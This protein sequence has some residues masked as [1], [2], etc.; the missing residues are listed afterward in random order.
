M[1][2]FAYFFDIGKH[3]KEVPLFQYIFL[4]WGN[5]SSRSSLLNISLIR[6][7]ILRSYP[8][9]NIFSETQLWCPLFLLF[10][11]LEKPF[12][13]SS[14]LLNRSLKEIPIFWTISIYGNISGSNPLLN[15][16]LEKHTQKSLSFEHFFG[17]GKYFIEIPHFWM[18][19]WFQKTFKRSSPH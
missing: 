15:I 6:E 14:P 8:L 16:F 7:I 1:P 12:K 9:L 3:V 11:W 4:V 5:T 2:S 17:F 19:I 10:L 13:I 18:H